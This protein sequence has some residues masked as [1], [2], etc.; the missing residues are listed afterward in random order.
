M[1]SLSI[2]LDSQGFAGLLS[3]QSRTE[4]EQRKPFSLSLMSETEATRVP[5][6]GARRER[7]D[8]TVRSLRLVCTAGGASL[9]LRHIF[10]IKVNHDR[11]L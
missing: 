7:L 1:D 3:V 8:T 9:D 11:F 2:L 6:P 4:T 10:L 5:E